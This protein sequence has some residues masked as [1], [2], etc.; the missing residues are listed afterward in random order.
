MTITTGVGAIVPVRINIEEQ[1][2]DVLI[3]SVVTGLFE[4][5]F[6]VKRDIKLNWPTLVELRSLCF[7]NFRNKNYAWHVLNFVAPELGIVP[8]HCKISW[9]GEIRSDSYLNVIV[10]GVPRH[11]PAQEDVAP[12]PRLSSLFT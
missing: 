9:G 6:T 12:V 2:A 7:R 10:L 4:R 11:E 8:R 3:E 1:Q 5:V